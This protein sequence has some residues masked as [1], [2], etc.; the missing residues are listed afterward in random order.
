M[1]C[2]AYSALGFTL[3]IALIHE[4]IEATWT[5]IGW[6]ILI[7]TLY[8]VSDEFHQSFVPGRES[9][10]PDIVADAVGSCLGLFVYLKRS[11]WFRRLAKSS[12]A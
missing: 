9:T 6:A 11:N 2:I 12:E 8:G 3:G 1:H 7:G 10:I 4:G 5:R